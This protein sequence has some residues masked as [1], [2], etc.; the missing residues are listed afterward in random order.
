MI[1]QSLSPIGRKV[2]MGEKNVQP[3]QKSNLG[4]SEYHIAALPT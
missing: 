1:I 2:S 4:P 3:E